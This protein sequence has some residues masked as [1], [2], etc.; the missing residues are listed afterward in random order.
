MKTPNKNKEVTLDNIENFLQEMIER[1]EP[2]QRDPVGRGRPRI[3]PGLC[4]WAGVV[5]CV[6]RGWNSQLAV[7]RLLSSKGLWDYPRFP[8]SDQAVY[9]RLEKGNAEP[10]KKLFRE[11]SKVLG[12]D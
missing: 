10:L 5:V 3:L 1:L 4:L 2:L 6:L 12:S 8:I 7:W 11:V 9:A